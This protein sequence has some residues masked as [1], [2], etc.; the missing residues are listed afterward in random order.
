MKD[1]QCDG[2]IDCT[3]GSDESEAVCRPEISAPKNPCVGTVCKA[4]GK[5]ISHNWV[6]D[7]QDDCPDGEDEGGERHKLLFF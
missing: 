5:C 3:D 4:N 1:W 7:K 2:D 6:C